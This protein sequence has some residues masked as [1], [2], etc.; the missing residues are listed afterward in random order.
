MNPD[1]L[2]LAL[3]NHPPFTLHQLTDEAR[4]TEQD[5]KYASFE[6]LS[7]DGEVLGYVKTWREEDDFSGFVHF[8]A[9]GNV[10]AWK[11]FTNNSLDPSG[12]R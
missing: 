5:E 8:D 7:D 9:H 2:A 11:T 12:V 6:M 3:G 10:L 4:E 1:L